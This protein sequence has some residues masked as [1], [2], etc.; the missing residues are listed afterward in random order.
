MQHQ[1]DAQVRDP[2]RGHEIR[3]WARR[4]ARG[5][6]D[7][8]VQVYVDGA[9]IELSVPE[10]AGPEWKTEDEALRAGVERGRYLVDK[11]VDD[12]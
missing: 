5:A 11:R 9:R 12:D 2:Y 3:V 1:Q 4:N 8:E 7:D 6:W 10:P